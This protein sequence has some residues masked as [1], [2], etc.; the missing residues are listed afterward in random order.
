MRHLPMVGALPTATRTT[1]YLL[2]KQNNNSD[3][4]LVSTA[5]TTDFDCPTHSVTAVS[6]PIGAWASSEDPTDP[7]F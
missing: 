3:T 7:A 5:Q 4:F 6:R 2:V 1:P